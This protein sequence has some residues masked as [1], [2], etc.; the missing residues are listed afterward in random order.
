MNDDGRM[1]GSLWT[2]PS[3]SITRLGHESCQET[4]ASNWVLRQPIAKTP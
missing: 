3:T 4:G 1:Q 2:L